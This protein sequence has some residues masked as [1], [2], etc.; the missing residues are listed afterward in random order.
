MGLFIGA[1]AWTAALFARD[2]PPFTDLPQH[3]WTLAMLRNP[4]SYSDA[5]VVTLR[6][7]HTNSLWFVVDA[8]LSRVLSPEGSL[9]LGCALAVVTLPL[10]LGAWA[11]SLGRSA[12]LALTLGWWV[13]WTRPLYW[14]FLNYSLSLPVGIAALALDASAQRPGADARPWRTLGLAALLV[15]VYLL[16]AQTWAF[17]LVA[18]AFQRAAAGLRGLLPR[19]GGLALV[20]LPSVALFLPFAVTDLVTPA[21]GVAPIATLLGGLKPR[22]DDAGVLLQFLLVNATASLKWSQV[23]DCL[24]A[25]VLAAAAFFLGRAVWVRNDPGRDWLPSLCAIALTALGC[26][27]FAPVNVLGQFQIATRMAPWV[28]L[29]A[30]PAASP[31]LRARSHQ[32]LL[33]LYAAGAVETQYLQ[34]V[35]FQR[36]Q[37]EAAPA[38]TILDRIEPGKRVMLWANRLTS[39]SAYGFVYVHFIGWYAERTLGRAQFSF[40]E[41]RPN[42]VVYKDALHYPR[43]VA[44]EETQPWCAALAGDGLGFDYLVTRGSGGPDAACG[45]IQRYRDSLQEVTREKDW[46][47]YAVIGTLPADPEN[48]CDCPKRSPRSGP[49]ALGGEPPH[50]GG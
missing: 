6:P 9:G 5:F 38:L 17:V 50:G 47:I 3:A 36:F 11:R 10:A 13:A 42:P 21:Q 14:G 7:W 18:L 29:A 45:S 32:L 41:F 16:H 22:F 48:D 1:S 26:Y 33:V 25:G 31:I 12:G 39:G 46:T 27:L 37:S 43:V 2:V 8:A 15:V 28:L 35:T 49:P 40:A 23:D 19:F 24:A 44:G 30:V 20:A 34:A 4:A